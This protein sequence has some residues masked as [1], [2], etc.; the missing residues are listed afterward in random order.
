MTA[1]W[2]E[3]A[4][5]LGFKALAANWQEYADEPMI[6]KLLAEEEAAA[7]RRSLEM[8]LRESHIHE[9]RPI[10]E[11]D[12]GFPK[13][14]DRELVEEL[15]T[16]KFLHE[17]ANV[18][19]VGP[20]G[21]GKTMLAKNL[22]HHAVMFGYKTRFIPASQMLTE[23]SSQD[24]ASARLRCLRKY[25]NPALLV[26]DE[27]GYLSY[28]NRYADLLYEVIN[29]RYLK[30][31]TIITTNK[32]F[33]EWGEIFPNAGCVVTLVDRLMHKAE[34]VAIHGDSFRHR[35]A[36]QRV[37]KRAQHRA[38]SKKEGASNVESTDPS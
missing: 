38:K 6:K 13:T 28:D 33:K 4:R 18:V 14:I 17:P 26:I 19:F 2:K 12:W 20:N 36:K 10:A 23:L 16:L 29:A 7:N 30:K 22:A 27:L 9:M 25:T 3:L 24:G 8:R 37:Q 34:I 21:V 11:F 31:A 32:P 1:N 15:F 5:K 35:E